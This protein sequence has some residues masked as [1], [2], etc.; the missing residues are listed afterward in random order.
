M[1][2]PD[3]VRPFYFLEDRLRPRRR[4][5]GRRIV[6]G[7]VDVEVR[8]NSAPASPSSLRLV[9][10]VGDLAAIFAPDVNVVTLRRRP[11]RVLVEET[12]RI[13]E[14]PAPPMRWLGSPEA[15]AQEFAGEFPTQPT[16]AR[17]I[18]LWSEVLS[19]LCGCDRIGARWVA[20]ETAMCP[21]FH[22]DYVTL[23]LVVTYTGPGTEYVA[24]EHV[25]RGK[26][27]RPSLH[28]TDER[29]GLLRPCARVEAARAF[30]VVL[31]KGEAWAGN[32]GRG[33]V[34]RSPRVP[35]GG[36]RVVL[37]LDPL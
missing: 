35:P 34:H 22:V 32:E 17:D 31:L 37:T 13:A 28:A 20:T 19:D 11:A 29:S 10:S 23:R 8:P 30:D 4:P 18:A 26:L 7:G 6:S 9:D 14:R 36:A 3:E 12:R 5:A 21:R 1:V 16:L 33:A 25:D 15:L 27:G 24:S 2:E